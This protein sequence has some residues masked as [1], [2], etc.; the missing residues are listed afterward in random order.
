MP[1]LRIRH[2]TW[3]RPALILT[4]T[5]DPQCSECRGHGGRNRYIG[6]GTTGEDGETYW[7]SCG[8]WNEGLRRVLLPLPR[9]KRP[10]A[11]SDEPP[12]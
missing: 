9:R 8:C 1:R 2:I 6:V 3:P 10:A 4:D 12:F 5:P 7:E 11:Y